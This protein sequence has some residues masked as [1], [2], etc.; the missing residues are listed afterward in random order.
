MDAV[1]LRLLLLVFVGETLH[2]L[3]RIVQWLLLISAIQLRL[4]L[5]TISLPELVVALRLWN[6]TI[7]GGLEGVR[8]R[9]GPLV[10]GCQ[11]LGT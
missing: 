2:S 9:D 3:V 7:V 1:S 5:E 10:L 6:G 4:G 11:G 8:L